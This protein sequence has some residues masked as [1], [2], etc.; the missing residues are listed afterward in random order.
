MLPPSAYAAL[1]DRLEDLLDHVPSPDSAGEFAVPEDR[2]P[3]KVV[4]AEACDEVG[5][6]VSAIEADDV[7]R[8]EV[9]R[10]PRPV[11]L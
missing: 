2:Y 8:H 10:L 7:S 5:H 9:L 6:A 11:M 4:V 3:A 1:A